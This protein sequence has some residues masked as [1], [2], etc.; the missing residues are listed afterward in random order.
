MPKIFLSPSVQE[1][2]E[3]LTGGSE[4]Y[5]MNLIAD[6][7]EPY[8]EASGIEFSRNDTSRPVSQA[9]ADS[10]A[11]NYDLHLSIHSNASPES[12]KGQL[13]GVDIYYSPVSYLG[14]MFADMLA[15]NYK[16]IYPDPD[17]VKIVPTTSLGEIRRTTAPAVLIETAYHDNPE[18]E[19]WIKE[20]IDL[21]AETLAMTVAEFFNLPF[22]APIDNNSYEI[23]VDMI[24]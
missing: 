1:Y 17:K 21:I 5:Y 16:K 3:Y 12:M 18:D 7:I 15:E 19:Q 6:E 13:L 20:N 23:D 9:I 22:V 2:N 24:E 11:G 14:K 10:N 4:E 8:L